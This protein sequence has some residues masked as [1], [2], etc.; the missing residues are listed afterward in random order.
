[1]S[2]PYYVN[3]YESPWN[4]NRQKTPR[5]AI[6]AEGVPEALTRRLHHAPRWQF[7]CSPGIES[8]NGR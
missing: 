8:A 6:I 7:E 3:P 5:Q 4:L 2:K 1:M